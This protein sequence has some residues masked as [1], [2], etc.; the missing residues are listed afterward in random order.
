MVKKHEYYSKIVTN[1]GNDQKTLFS[2]ANELLDKGK[3][4]SLLEHDDPIKLANE[5]NKYYIE[6]I[7][8]I[9][10]PI[11]VVSENVITPKSFVGVGLKDFE[12]TTEKE[13]EDI[14]KEFGIKTSSEDPIPS[15]ILKTVIN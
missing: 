8:K 9:R 14:I 10:E 11:P 5:F 15:N 12:P 4:R 13:L 1:A 2:V 7:E 6:K 3:V